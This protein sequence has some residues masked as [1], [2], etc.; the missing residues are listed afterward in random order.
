MNK[1]VIGI[2][3]WREGK[4]FLEPQYFRQ[5]IQAGNELGAT[6]FLFSPPDVDKGERKVRGYIPFQG[7]WQERWFPLPDVVIDRFRYTPK[8]AF[9]EYVQFRKQ[10]SLLFANNRLANKWRVHQVLWKVETMRK[11]LPETYSYQ[12]GILQE[13]L[14]RHKTI[15]L[16]PSNGTG[17]RGILRIKKTASGYELLGRTKARSKIQLQV[18]NSAALM[19]HVKSWAK[20]EL[21]V[22]Q[23]GL[24]LDLIPGR[25][26][27]IR[28]MIQKNGEGQWSVTGMGVRVGG[29]KSAT[30]NLHGGGKA[31]LASEFLT[32]RFGEG[33]TNEIIRECHD[34]AHQ[35]AQTLENH[36]GRLL[37]LGLDIGI[38]V[39]G[40]VWLIEV[41]PKPGRE[42]F[43][44]M[45]QKTRY[46]QAIKRPIE[47][48]IYL[49]RLHQK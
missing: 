21:F 20:H 47:Y 13:L 49:S 31:V 8:P 11:W 39:D 38:D 22:V 42:I 2:L 36:F 5:L 16:K 27:D 4:K 33:Q 28:L 29:I 7:A 6:V 40:R 48:A 3:T 34:L 10:S 17:G 12:S 18:T 23:Q 30:S 35:T 25:S 45:G 37:E 26:I 24:A 41:N 44:Q 19:K 14:A 32:P 9:R 15:F 43:R 1:P 46:A